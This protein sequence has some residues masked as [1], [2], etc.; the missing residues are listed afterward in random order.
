MVVAAGKALILLDRDFR[1]LARLE[2]VIFPGNGEALELALCDDAVLVSDHALVRE[3][4]REELTLRW[5]RALSGS[6]AAGTDK[7]VV[8]GA[9]GLRVLNRLTG[10]T[11]WEDGGAY[12]SFALY[13]ERIYAVDALGKL[14]AYSGPA[15]QEAPEISIRLWPLEPDGTNGWYI[16]K[17]SARIAALDRETFTAEVRAW[18]NDEEREDPSTPFTLED[19]EYQITGY[20]VDSR[21][22]RSAL[23]RTY[24]KVDTEL[25]RSDYAL[26]EAEPSGGWYR[27]PVTVSLEGWDDLSGLDRIWTSEGPYTAPVVFSRQGVH[28]FSWYALDRAGNHEGLRHREIR[29]DFEP[30]QAELQVFTDR[31]IT[32]ARIIAVD[33]V[34]GVS[35]VEYRINGGSIMEY[36]EPLVFTEEGGYRIQYRALDRAGNQGEWQGRDIWVGPDLAEVSLLSAVSVGGRERLVLGN[37]RNGMPILRNVEGQRALRLD[38]SRPEALINLPSYVLG[39]EYAVW[40]PEDFALDGADRVRFRVDREALAYLFLPRTEEAPGDWSF[41]EEISRINRTYYPEGIRVY[42]K[43][44]AAGAWTELPGGAVPPLL[45]V[46]ERGSI[47]AEIEIREAGPEGE[48]SSAEE[49]A[50]EKAAGE[51]APGTTLILEGIVSPWQYSRRLPLRKLWLVNTEAGWV[52]LEEDR[53]EIPGTLEDAFLRFR[54]E[55]YTPDGQREYRA[56]KTIGVDH[57]PI[58]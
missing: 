6:L 5:S 47:S 28:N 48:E 57:R 41:V 20:A 50:T 29:I 38:R 39:A 27:S 9:G 19:G 55:L 2:N 35:L 58:E 24:L 1:E 56:E 54:L 49:A 44:L 36:R 23:A 12:R 37:L 51:F 43:R 16:T 30:P 11:I 21:G 25:P 32:E 15:N 31:S 13:R 26:S 52:P 14:Y 8:A 45:A 17:P 34:S 3:F 46:Q 53:Y 22:L 7:A 40:E 4:D 42:M 18:I 10:E 33:W